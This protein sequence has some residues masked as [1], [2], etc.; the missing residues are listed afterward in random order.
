MGLAHL[1]VN[2]DAGGIILFGSVLAGAVYDRI[3]LKHRSDPGGRRFPKA[4]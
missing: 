4:D 2:G 1:L 3:T